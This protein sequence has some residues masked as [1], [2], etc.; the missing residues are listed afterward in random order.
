MARGG[1][2][3]TSGIPLYL[4]IKEILRAEITEGT[5]DTLSPVTEAML[6]ERFG[7]SRAPIRQAL[8]ELTTEGYVYRKQGKGT[9]PVTGVRVARPADVRPGDLYRFLAERGL[10]P[11][12]T[13][14]DLGRVAPPP[15][16]A[17]KLG[18]GPSEPVL[19]FRRLLTLEGR[20]F[21]D[22]EIYIRTP[23][24]FLPRTAELDDGGSAFALLEAEFG[25]TVERSEHDAWATAATD[26]QA[27]ALAVPVGSPLLVIDT[28]FYTT[29]G[30]PGG[31]R[32]AVHRAEDFKF[33]FITTP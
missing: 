28:L 14:S 25:I 6:L 32:R 8:Q 9:F 30:V 11:G 22:N 7:V 13:V 17:Q 16:I 15:D 12:S 20:P 21:A 26:E 19:H 4:Q 27:A 23:D 24:G 31:W 10:H 3:H 29:G 2:D 1:L 18:I 33:S 5:A